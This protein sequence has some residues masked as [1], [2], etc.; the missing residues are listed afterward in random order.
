VFLEDNRPIEAQI[1]QLSF[2]LPELV[3]MF[4]DITGGYPAGASITLA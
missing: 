4:G 3:R 1:L 2:D